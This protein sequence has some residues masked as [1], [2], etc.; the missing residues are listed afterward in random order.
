LLLNVDDLSITLRKNGETLVQSISFSLKKG[1]SLVI[2]GQS[3]SGKTLTCK[4]ITGILNR[5]SFKT[6]GR[7]FFEGHEL[8]V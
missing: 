2:L 8:L 5:R 4:T 7:V 1:S 6:E 3:G